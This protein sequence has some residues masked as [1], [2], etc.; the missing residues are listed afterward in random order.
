MPSYWYD[1]VHLCSPDPIKTAEFY[2]EMF[3]ARRVGVREFPDGRINVELDLNGSRVLVMSPRAQPLAPGASQTGYDRLEHFGLRTDNLEAAVNEL[4]TK[5][6]T[7]VQEITQ[8]PWIK[9]SFFLAPE[10]V[11]IEL[12]ER[13]G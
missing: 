1:H 2:E 9:V 5:G 12:V 10:G 3:N 4:K 8:L 11:L 7:F 13:S 6:V